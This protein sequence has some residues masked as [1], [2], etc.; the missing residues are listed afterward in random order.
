ML[1]G[2][3]VRVEQKRERAMKTADERQADVFYM[4]QLLRVSFNKMNV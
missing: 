2:K 4:V 1:V 3:N